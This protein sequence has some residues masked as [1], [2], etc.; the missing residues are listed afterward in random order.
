MS[1]STLAGFSVEQLEV[2]ELTVAALLAFVLN[3]NKG[4]NPVA[5]WTVGQLSL[6]L[7]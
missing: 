4:G 2:Q 7:L 5:K 6:I 1:G 3:G